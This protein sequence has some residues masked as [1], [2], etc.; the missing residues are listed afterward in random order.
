[1]ASFFSRSL[2]RVKEG[3]EQAWRASNFQAKVRVSFPQ[4]FAVF[5]ITPHRKLSW[6]EDLRALH[7]CIRSSRAG[8]LAWVFRSAAQM[9]RRQCLF[10][11]EVTPSTHTFLPSTKAVANGALAWYL[12]N[13]VSARINKYHYGTEISTPWISSD[14]EI[15]SRP[16]I[17]DASGELVV[18]GAWSSIVAQVNLQVLATNRH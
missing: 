6:L 7:T 1:V 4:G 11:P 17:T 8:A 13:S 3:L 12:D 2:T 5:F 16:R 15:N 10:L 14:P 18:T 9:D